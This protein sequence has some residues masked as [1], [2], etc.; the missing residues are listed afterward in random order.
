L[1]RSPSK[2][3]LS[4]EF[5]VVE[6][7]QQADWDERVKAGKY[8][9]VEFPDKAL[10]YLSTGMSKDDQNYV[11]KAFDD[12]RW[13]RYWQQVLPYVYGGAGPP[14]VLLL[15]GSFL[16]WVGRGFARGKPRLG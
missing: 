1:K 6:W 11:A 9:S 12:Q 10:L 14:I 2:E 13:Q 5:S 8:G 3:H 16:V 7:W 4:P 15:I